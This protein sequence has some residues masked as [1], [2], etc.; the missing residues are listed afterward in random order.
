MIQ[1]PVPRYLINHA[2]HQ[3]NGQHDQ[4]IKLNNEDVKYQRIR[5]CRSTTTQGQ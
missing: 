1:S 4:E 3:F 2:K 5:Q